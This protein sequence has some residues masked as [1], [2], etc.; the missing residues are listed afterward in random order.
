MSILKRNRMNI[1][2]VVITL[3]ITATILHFNVFRFYGYKVSVGSSTITFIKNKSEFNKTYKELQSEIKLK[4]SNVIVAQDFTLDKV[5]VDDDVMFISGDELKKVM[6]KKFNIVVDAFVMKS[7]NRKIAYVSSQ[8]QGKE[9]LNS[10]KDYY[11]KGIKLSSI[12]AVDIENK[13][14]YESVKVKTGDLYGNS[15]IVSEVIK[16]NDKSQTPLVVVKIVGNI[17]KDQTVKPATIMTSSSELMSGVNKTMKEGI[18]GTKKVNMLITSINDKIVSEKILTSEITKPVQNKEVSVGT[19]EPTILVA[20]SINS[21]SRGSISS[22]FGKRWGKMHKGIDIAASFG[23]EISAAL[24]GTISYAGW[25][26][27]YGNVI[28]IDHGNGIETTYAHCSVITAQKGETVNKGT[29]IGE[30]GSTGNSTGPHLHFE[31]RENGVP[32]NPE[33]YIK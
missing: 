16:Y 8:N 25:E 22:P 31:V 6:L 33:A 5:R 20:A 27:G 7:D 24:D 26:T 29:K 4:Y 15:Q 17:V 2:V 3:M 14:S 23:Q 19:S 28:K 21:P 13:I 32:I 18:A 1:C 30:V 11:S 10:V 9:I 12:K